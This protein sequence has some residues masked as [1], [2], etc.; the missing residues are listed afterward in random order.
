MSDGPR[1]CWD[2]VAGAAAGNSENR[3][4]FGE[5]YLPI[6]R[7]YLDRRWRGK[8]MA[9]D[10]EDAVQ[11]VF[12]ECFRDGGALERADPDKSSGFRGFLFGITRNVA[13][14]FERKASADRAGNGLQTGFLEQIANDEPRLS[15]LFEREWARTV[16]REAG[17]LQ[18]RRANERGGNAL[19]RLD[20][21]RRRFEGGR[22]I[23]E[24]ASELGESPDLVHK[25]AERGRQD[26]RDCLREIVASHM[27]EPVPPESIEEECLRLL[28][29]LE[30]N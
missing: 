22:S 16:V 27:R 21:I 11:E 30:G 23:P 24:I 19:K 8:P 6:V 9:R 13:S 26:F 25:W 15:R 5:L 10:L 12:V 1:T 17:E 28:S 14:R 4:A 18:S 2:L 29:L 7:L 20:V 3:R